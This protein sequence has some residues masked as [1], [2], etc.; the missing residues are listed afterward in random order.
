MFMKTYNVQRCVYN[1]VL[2]G[3]TQEGKSR[4]RRSGSTSS[5][6]KYLNSRSSM[7]SLGNKTL[8]L[9]K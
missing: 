5:L 9:T 7:A 2:G 1:Y 8:S 6:I 4:S 3:G